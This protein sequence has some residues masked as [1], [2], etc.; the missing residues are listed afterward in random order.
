M[1]PYIPTH[2]KIGK[3]ATSVAGVLFMICLV[4]ALCFGIILYRV[5]IIYKLSK[6]NGLRPWSNYIASSTA[7]AINLIIIIVLNRFYNWVAAKLT[8]MGILRKKKKNNFFYLKNL[9]I[10][11]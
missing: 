7:A 4:L 3:Y 2:V 6:I 9:F 11:N 1:E 8:D 10:K 5:V